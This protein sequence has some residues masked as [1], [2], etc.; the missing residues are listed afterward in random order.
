MDFK[1][2]GL[3]ELI[4]ELEDLQSKAENLDGMEVSFE[5]LF[6]KSFM[7]RYT[8]FSTFEDLLLAGNFKVESEEDFLA[9]PDDVF[10]LHISQNT[11]F[12]DWEDMLSKA[13]EEYIAK[14]LDF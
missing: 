3:D 8:K 2:D 6:N 4:D 12:D 11:S 10:D 5:E 1:F 7:E 13:Q 14:E 9:I